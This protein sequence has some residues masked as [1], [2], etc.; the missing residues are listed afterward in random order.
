M[1]KLKIVGGHCLNGT[2]H[3]KGAK[4]AVLPLMA[5]GLLTSDKLTLNNVPHLADIINMNKLLSTL[6]SDVSQEENSLTIQSDNI[7]NFTAPYELVSQ[8]R[9]SFLVLGPLLARFGKANVTLPGGCSIG[10]RPVD[11]HLTALEQLGA[12][13][14]IENGLIYA[15]VE[16]KL[17]G[18]SI[19]FPKQTVGGTQ[20]ILMAATLA[21]G[22]TVLNNVAMEP[23]C[24]D[25]AHCLNAM[26]AKISGIGTP[27]LTIEGVETLHGATHN[28]IGDRIEAATYAV[29]AAITHGKIYITGCPLS[30]L[31]SV[32]EH[33]IEAGVQIKE[34]K[35][36][37]IS[38]ATDSVLV[39]TDMMTEVYPGFP[40]DVQ[41]QFMALMSTAYGASMITETIFENRFMHVPELKRMGANITIHGKSSAIVRGS[42]HLSGAPVM[43]TDLRGSVA[44]VLAALA[45]RGETTIS[46]IYH[47]DRG[48]DALEDKLR[49]CGA[50]IKRVK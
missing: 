23:E 18:C 39:G 33:L 12:K 22:I 25:L 9:A 11:L 43:A 24:A 19:T 49:S 17:K 28:V 42:Q 20:N 7:Q 21:E 47:L 14:K 48:Y 27:Q 44:L 8:M 31:S 4:N 29:A 26:G 38:D 13:I 36:G 6:G 10:S 15:S 45:A 37:F 50:E 30:Y 46:R 16:G 41:A 3:V 1:E 40:T 32:G 5:A 35:D 2:I 34:T